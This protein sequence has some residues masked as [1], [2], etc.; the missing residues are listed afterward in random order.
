MGSVGHIVRFV[1]VSAGDFATLLLTLLRQDE[2][3]FLIQS[4]WPDIKFGFQSGALQT[5][6]LDARLQECLHSLFEFALSVLSRAAAITAKF[7]LFA[8]R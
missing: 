8:F 6:I 7:S 3:E 4:Q 1:F 2:F 5:S